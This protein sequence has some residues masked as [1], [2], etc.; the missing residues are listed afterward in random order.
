[1]KVPGPVNR[2]VLRLLS[3]RHLGTDRVFVGLAIRG[4]R[5]GKVFRFPVQYVEDGTDLVVSPGHAS[6]KTW[7]RNLRGGPADLDVLLGGRWQHARGEVVRPGDADYDRLRASYVERWPK[8]SAYGEPVV[9][10]QV[11]RAGVEAG[12]G[13]P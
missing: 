6:S 7:W 9:R 13:R 3:G 10:I 4:R 2:L 8:A 5:S 1:M 12:G 11:D